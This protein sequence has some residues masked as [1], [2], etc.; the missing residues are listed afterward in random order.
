MKGRMWIIVLAIAL[1]CSVFLS[2][3]A[4]SH[5]DGLEKVAEDREFIDRAAEQPHINSPIPDYVM[6][7]IENEDIAVPV[8][9]LIGTVMV[10]LLTLII[11]KVLQKPEESS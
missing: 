6:P 10:F 9:G 5:P 1:V 4:S 3:F 8:A 11:A 7:G 2:P